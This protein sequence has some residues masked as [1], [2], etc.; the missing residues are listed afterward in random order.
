MAVFVLVG[1]VVLA[2]GNG[3][4]SAGPDG[5]PYPRPTPGVYPVKFPEWEGKQRPLPKPTVSYPIRFPSPG[6]G[7]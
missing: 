5:K 1:F 7:R 2:G 6:A 4:P 3:S